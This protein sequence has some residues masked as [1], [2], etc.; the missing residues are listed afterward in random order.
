MKYAIGRPINGISINGLEYVMDDDGELM[1]F[2][3]EEAAIA[4]LN[5]NGISADD[6]EDFGIEIV[7]VDE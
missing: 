5:Q 4:F 1:T 7:E 6:I 2:A 3:S